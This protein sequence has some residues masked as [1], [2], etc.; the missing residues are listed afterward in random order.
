MSYQTDIADA[1]RYLQQG[2]YKRALKSAHSAARLAP[3]SAVAPNLMGIALGASGKPSEAVAQFQKALKL[4]PDY[5]DA[6]KNLAQTLLLIG[7]AAAALPLLRELAKTMPDDWQVWRLKAH[8]HLGIGQ[9]R[10]ALDAADMSVQ[11]APTLATVF[12]FRSTVLLAQGRTRDAIA[13]LEA[14]LKIDPHDVESLT[15][16][17]LPLARQI[18]SQ[19]A[20][21]HVARAVEIDPDYLPARFRLAAQLVEM[22]KINEAITQYRKILDK[23]PTHAAALERLTEILPPQQRIALAPQITSALKHAPRPP[24][25]R[26]SLFFAQSRVADAQNNA[27]A[28]Q[29]NLAL[30]NKEMARLHRYDPAADAAVTTA[31]LTRFASQISVTATAPTAPVPVFVIG[32]PRSGTTLAEAMLG[33]HPHV[34]PFGELGTAG[35]VLRDTIENELPFATQDIAAF[36]SEDQRLLPDLPK[37]TRAYI[38]KMPENYRLVGFLKTA[39]PQARIIHIKRDPRDIALSMWKSHFSG[40]VLA[41]TYRLDWMAQKFNLYAQMMA[42]WHQVLPGAILDI[43]YEDMVRTPE[44]I[45]KRMA[46]FCDLDWTPEMARPDQSQNPVLT[47]SATQLRQP[48]H[49]GSIGNWQKNPDMLAEFI[50]G[51]DPALWPEAAN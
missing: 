44:D 22:G 34:T 7:R 4:K 14:A 1:A 27:A 23:T 9:E 26:A 33:A 13:D 31:I 21:G 49:T 50:S 24:E 5:A 10:A 42:H 16:I 3:T 12:K 48:V 38:D 30:A 8:A 11:K 35:F 45:S 39:Y 40:T 15:N 37:G 6:Q 41:Y 17:S 29:K 36:V 47:L 19:E 2:N 18:R 28:V 51:L 46:A 43:S 20:L 25:D 32:L